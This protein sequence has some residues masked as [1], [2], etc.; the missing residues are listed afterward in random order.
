MIGAT[1]E[2]LSKAYLRPMSS[3]IA[4]VVNEQIPHCLRSFLLPG[5]EENARR[6][7]G[8]S[9]IEEGEIR[10]SPE[11]RWIPFT[12]RQFIDAT[13]SQFRWEARL[14]PDKLTGPT[15]IDAYENGHG[16]LAVKLGGILPVKKVT[17][18]DADKGELQRYLASVMF[19]P[20]MLLN[21]PH[22][23]WNAVEP[24]TLRLRDTTDPTGATVDLEISEAGKPA[25]VH[26]IRPRIVGKNALLTPW[27]GT[28]C[29]FH[30][31]EGLRIATRLQV[32]WQLPQ[33][34]FIYYRSEIKS[35]GTID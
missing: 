11:A 17:G 28:A 2:R 27:T 13:R 10:M 8:V 35:I 30:E 7:R 18:P 21:N 23:E 1:A 14:D 12:A 3:Q 33:A 32:A 15:V 22:L 29:E 25:A 20:S 4:A 26:T 19:C 24:T 6:I 31:H 16:Y 9:L 5:G 34:E